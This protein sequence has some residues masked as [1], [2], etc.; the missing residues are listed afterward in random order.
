MIFPRFFN[1]KPRYLKFLIPSLW[2]Q[3]CMFN[4]FRSG[5]CILYTHSLWD[6]LLNLNLIL[7]VNIDGLTI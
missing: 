6:S 1:S 3:P 4:H 5:F 7:S 2:D